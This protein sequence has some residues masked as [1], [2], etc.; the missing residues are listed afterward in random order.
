MR[1]LSAIALL[2]LLSGAALHAA[3]PPLPA[4]S[5][6][7]HCVRAVTLP[8]RGD[9]GSLQRAPADP[10]EPLLY[11]A[12]DH[13]VDGCSMLLMHRTGQLRAV[14]PV[15]LPHPGSN[16]WVPLSQSPDQPNG[17][18]IDGAGVLNQR[19]PDSSI[20]KQSSSRIPNAPG[21]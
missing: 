1:S 19:E 9:G 15:P 20:Q 16:L 13:R 3:D 6:D 4:I 8:A 5:A 7:E 17:S 10:E 2:P 11:K 21:M 14:P 18:S 12:V